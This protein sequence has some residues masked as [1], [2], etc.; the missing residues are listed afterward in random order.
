MTTYRE[1]RGLYGEPIRVP[2][3]TIAPARRDNRRGRFPFAA[4]AE[5]LGEERGRFADL[6]LKVKLF[7][8]LERSRA[9][10]DGRFQLQAA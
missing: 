1:Y 9:Y 6:A 3:D 5:R 2:E 8:D 7:E 10:R 4:L